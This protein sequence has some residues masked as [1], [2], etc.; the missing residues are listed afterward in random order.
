MALEQVTAFEQATIEY[1]YL[2]PILYLR[3][4]PALVEFVASRMEVASP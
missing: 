4:G 2:Y 1:R 3:A